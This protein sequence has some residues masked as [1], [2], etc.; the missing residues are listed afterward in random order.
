VPD[1]IYKKKEFLFVIVMWKENSYKSCRRT[2]R[3]KFP[4]TTCQSG[5]T[6]YKLVTNVMA[7]GN[8]IGRKPLKIHSVLTEG[9]LKDN[10]RR[11][12]NSRIPLRRLTLQGGVSLGSA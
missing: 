10:G 2:F 6:I 3:L 9:K 7:H 12:E 4:D 8:V 11:L 1:T 5:G